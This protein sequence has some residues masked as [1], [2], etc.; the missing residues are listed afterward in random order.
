VEGLVDG[1]DEALVH[2]PLPSPELGPE[3]AGH[4]S[5]AGELLDALLVG[6]E[7]D[8][9]G[10]DDVVEGRRAE[11]VR[12]RN[13]SLYGASGRTHPGGSHANRLLK[14]ISARSTLSMFSKMKRT[15]G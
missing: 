1:V 6:P 4:E 12:G 13:G 10:V 11:H 14:K 5:D 8:R 7:H 3:H 2:D 9:R 15:G